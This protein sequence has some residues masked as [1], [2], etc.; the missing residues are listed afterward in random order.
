M[1]VEIAVGM[2]WS[3][4]L[5]LMKRGKELMPKSASVHHRR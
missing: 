2:L 1:K 3:F 4:L 5:L